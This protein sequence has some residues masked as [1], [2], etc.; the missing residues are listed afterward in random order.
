MSGRRAQRNQVRLGESLPVVPSITCGDAGRQP[1]GT[2]A[3]VRP[4]DGASTTAEAALGRAGKAIRA[5]PAR[6]DVDYS[7]GTVRLELGRWSREHL[8]AFDVL[9]RDR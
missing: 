8:D 3:A 7:G 2:V 9:G 5:L 4:S 1:S 6:D